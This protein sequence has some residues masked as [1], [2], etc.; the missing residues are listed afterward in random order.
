M[1]S[2]RPS[3]TAGREPRRAST[4]CVQLD[5][6]VLGVALVADGER[7]PEAHLRA[8]ARSP[9]VN[10][11]GQLGDAER[12]LE[13]AGDVAVRDEPHRAALR[14]S[15]AAPGTRRHPATRTSSPRPPSTLDPGEQ[16]H[17]HGVAD[18][19]ILAGS[20][21]PARGRDGGGHHVLERV[22]RAHPAVVARRP[23]TIGEP[24]LGERRLP[25]VPR[26]SPGAVRPRCGPTGA[27]RRRC[28]GG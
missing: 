18:G 3:E 12:P 26:G 7:G 2:G 24:V 16:L 22:A 10:A 8:R 27:P 15:G 6:E 1:P 19:E 4:S 5:V 17:R 9:R 14:R 25:V 11:S 23:P 20:L 28:G 13:G 21:A